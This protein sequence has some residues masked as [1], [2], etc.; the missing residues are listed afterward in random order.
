MTP[1]AQAKSLGTIGS[2]LV[3]FAAIPGIGVLLGIVGF[4][5]ILVAIKYVSDAVSDGT[6]FRDMLIATVLAIA[7]IVTGTLLVF[8][9]FFHFMGITGLTILSF[10]PNFNASAI[11]AGDWVA[12]F[13][14]VIVGLGV[15]WAMLLASAILVRRT[16]GVIASRLEVPV[17]RTAG[18]LYLIGAATTLILVGFLLLIVSQILL[19]VAFFSIDEGKAI[20]ASSRGQIQQQPPPGT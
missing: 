18:L 17:F 10:G 13:A 9:A 1:L 7:G 5:M 14:S 19:A 16:Y 6:I 2:I 15:T 12:L 20:P 3:L 11:P 8:G 4:I